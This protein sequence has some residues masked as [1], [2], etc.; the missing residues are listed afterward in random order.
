[1]R[2]RTLAPG[3]YP[4]NRVVLP[5]NNLN[6]IPKD[7]G[8]GNR[9]QGAGVSGAGSSRAGVSEPALA[10]VEA[11]LLQTVRELVQRRNRVLENLSL[12][13][14]AHH[15]DTRQRL[16]A[17]ARDL[18]KRARSIYAVVQ[19]AEL[20]KLE[21]ELDKLITLPGAHFTLLYT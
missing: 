20:V 9:G 19:R 3:S 1:V 16:L 10:V 2:K 21:M 5:D 14:E 17:L 11:E 4:S 12:Y 6:Q 13:V 8:A 15:S 18:D 7:R